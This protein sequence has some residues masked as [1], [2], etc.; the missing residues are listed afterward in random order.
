MKTFLELNVF[1]L[2]FEIWKVPYDP[3]LTHWLSGVSCQSVKPLEMTISSFLFLAPLVSKA[4]AESKALCD[5]TE[6]TYT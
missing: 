3:D 5:V 4:C 2:L 1:T 6:G